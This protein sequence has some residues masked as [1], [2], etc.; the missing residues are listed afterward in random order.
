MDLII[1]LNKPRDITSQDAVTKAKKAI[2]VK[3]AGHTGTLDPIA[4]GL[5]LV[6]INRATRLASY[7]SGLDKEYRT[8]MKLGE[9][10]DTQDAYG[11]IISRTD[12][13]R[14]DNKAL[15]DTI[16]SFRGTILQQPPMYSALKHEGKPLYKL[17]RKGIEVERAHR[18]VTIHDIE[19]LS[20]EIPYVTFRAVCSKG[21]Y[22]RTLCDDIGKKLGVG[23]HLSGLERTAIGDFRIEDSLTFEELAGLNLEIAH[24]KGIYTMDEAL[25]WMPGLKINDQMAKA[26]SHGN[27]LK[28][29]GLA[30][31]FRSAAGIRIRS[32]RGEL[33][34]VGSYSPAKDMVQMDIVFTN[35]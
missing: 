3:K 24:P 20:A 26:A 13:I 19:I 6:C 34:A 5:L 7:F 31:A 10:T 30:E 11:K 32:P 18:E 4:T 23:A 33:I 35:E 12:D 14:I 15:E 2:K 28:I 27:P 1:A 17:A 22:M 8:T 29:M 25:S 21:T 9:A 16:L